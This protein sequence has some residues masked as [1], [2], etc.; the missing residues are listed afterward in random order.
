M[1]LERWLAEA[2]ETVLESPHIKMKRLQHY[3]KIEKD[4]LVIAEVGTARFRMFVQCVVAHELQILLDRR[5]GMS[6]RQ[7]PLEEIRNY[8]Q[9]LK[10]A[11]LGRELR[12]AR[13]A[14][15]EQAMKIENL[16]MSVEGGAPRLNI[17]VKVEQ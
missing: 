16:V 11:E 4:R 6:V 17:S 14:L 12:W 3:I 7:E 2:A 9:D 10:I 5:K 13:K 8:N 15:A 1:G